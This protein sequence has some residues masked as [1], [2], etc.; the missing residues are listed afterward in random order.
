MWI[1]FAIGTTSD[2]LG[3]LKESVKSWNSKGRTN[4]NNLGLWQRRKLVVSRFAVEMNVKS[5][6]KLCFM[7]TA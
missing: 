3:D 2:Q 5:N 7:T 4:C 1:S 6:G